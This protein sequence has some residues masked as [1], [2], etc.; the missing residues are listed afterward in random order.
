MEMEMGKSWKWGKESNRT[1]ATEA[2]K[3]THKQEFSSSTHQLTNDPTE[4]LLKPTK[5]L[6][7]NP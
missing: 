5:Q 1:E 7:K 3:F 4:I 6:R 2:T